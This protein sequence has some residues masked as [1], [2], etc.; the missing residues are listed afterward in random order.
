MT[1]MDSGHSRVNGIKNMVRN[2]HSSHILNLN[3]QD[4]L[5]Y[6]HPHHV[7]MLTFSKLL[8]KIHNN[9]CLTGTLTV[10]VLS[11]LKAFVCPFSRYTFKTFGRK[12]REFPW[13]SNLTGVIVVRQEFI[14]IEALC[15]H[16]KNVHIQISVSRDS[17]SSEDHNT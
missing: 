12:R 13:W 11:N 5:Q 17:H 6:K 16:R 9:R 2:T 10:V 7:K 1:S 4:V 15:P 8:E 3:N 14:L